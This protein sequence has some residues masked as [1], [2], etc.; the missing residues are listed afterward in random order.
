MSEVAYKL[1]MFDAI[2]DV[3]KKNAKTEGKKELMKTITNVKPQEQRN[4][5]DATPKKELT[6]QEALKKGQAQLL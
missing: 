1:E 6:Y 5:A 2:V 4:I 3:A